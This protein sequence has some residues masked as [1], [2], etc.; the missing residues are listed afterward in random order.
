MKL[1]FTH[2]GTE[3]TLVKHPKVAAALKAGTLTE[4][5]A[6][7]YP[8]YLRYT[9]NGQRQSFNLK[10]TG[11]KDAITAAKDRLKATTTDD[12]K[13]F[14]QAKADHAS[15]TIGA[16]AQDWIAADL[17]FRPTKLRNAPAAA[18]IKATLNRALPWWTDK[19]VATINAPTCE[20]YAEHRAPALRSADLELSALSSLCQWAVLA[21]KIPRNPFEK[22][23]KFAVCKQHCHEACPD[24]DE[25]LHKVLAWL[26][27]HTGDVHHPNSTR[28]TTLAAGTL[29]FCALTGLRP[30]EP[31]FLTRQPPLAEPPAN[32]RLLLPGQI[33]PDRS[34]QLRMKVQRL[35]HG[36]NPFVTLP[37]AAESFLSSWRAWMALNLPKETRL[38]PLLETNATPL[39]TALNLATSAMELPHFKPHGMRAY[40]VK[41]RR[42]QG[43]DDATISG[44]LGQTTNGQLIRDVYGDPQDLIGGALF[45][46]LPEDTAPAWNLLAAKVA[47]TQSPTNPPQPKE[48]VTTHA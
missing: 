15:V 29:T 27:A 14:Q 40:Y 9:A 16:L 19:P 39:N 37:P 5:Q 36:Q 2:L 31:S 33:F 12:F 28:N 38:F 25:M 23:G 42:A 43:E 41:V 4:E 10:V 20:A 11:E 3:R 46:W 6:R 47:V 48:K 26:F 45:D 34:G 24:N 7:A 1:L 35:K 13:Q 30:G 21:G 17:R 18:H 22:R 44:E 32:T 8:W